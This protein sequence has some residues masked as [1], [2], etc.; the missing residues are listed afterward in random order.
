MTDF[1]PVR[2]AEKFESA[3]GVTSVTFP[4]DD[5]E[6]QPEQGYRRGDAP[7]VGADY[8]VDF[9]AGSAWAKEPALE[10]VRFILWGASAADADTQFDTLVQKC[11]NIGLGKLYQLDAAGVRRWCWAKLRGRP[12]YV[13]RSEQFWNIPVV[14]SFVRYSDWF[15]ASATTGSRTITTTPDTFTINNPGNA[16]ARFIVFR[17]RANGAS[18]FTNPNLTNL[19]NG[20]ASRCVKTN[21]G[22]GRPSSSARSFASAAASGPSGSRR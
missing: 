16:A 10:S 17:F 3:D 2:Y 14:L 1:A 6:Y 20:Y 8:A 5:Y 7:V 18:G 4:G 13:V 11:R 21:A 15:A 22:T 19:T 12:A 9:A